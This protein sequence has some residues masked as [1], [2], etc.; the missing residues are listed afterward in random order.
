MTCPPPSPCAFAIYVFIGVLMCGLPVHLSRTLAGVDLRSPTSLAPRLQT[1]QIQALMGN[2]FEKPLLDHLNGEPC[3]P[4]R[5]VPL[6][7][8]CPQPLQ[9]PSGPFPLPR[10]QG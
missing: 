7:P 3:P 5:V 4:L 2:V 6:D 10:L 1:D 9:A 8:S